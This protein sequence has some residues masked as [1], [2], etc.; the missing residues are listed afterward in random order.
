MG[1]D[2]GLKP[3]RID[4]QGPKPVGQGPKLGGQGLK[5]TDRD[6]SHCTGRH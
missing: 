1:V 4:G 2:K 3:D 5:L 6:L